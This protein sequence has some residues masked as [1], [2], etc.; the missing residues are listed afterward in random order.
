MPHDVRMDYDQVEDLIQ[1]YR[2]SVQQL[3]ETIRAM[4]RIADM[5]DGGALVNQRGQEWSSMLRD[6]L[7]PRLNTAQDELEEVVHDLDFAVRELRDGDTDARG[8]F[9]S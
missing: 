8:R 6:R 7:N 5:L 9:S 4:Q 1:S 3:T 2:V